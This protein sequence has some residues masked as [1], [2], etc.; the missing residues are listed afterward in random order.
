MLHFV[1]WLSHHNS[2]TYKVGKSTLFNSLAQQSIARAENFPFCT[3]DPNVAPVAVPDSFL[4]PLSIVGDSL[5][6][7]PAMIEWIDVAGLAKG[8]HRG[9]GLGNRFLG[10]LRECNAICHVVRMFDDPN[11]IHV[12]GAVDPLVDAEVINLELLLADLAHVERRL[13]RTTCM[14][15]TGYI[16]KG[17]GWTEKW[18]TCKGSRFVGQ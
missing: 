15:R 4:H 17:G 8:A 6:I 1:M 3:V 5:H 14:S 9:E 11:V 13:E 2:L 18:R 12:D 7:K 10:T 16:G